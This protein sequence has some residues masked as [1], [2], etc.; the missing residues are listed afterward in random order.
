MWRLIAISCILVC[1]GGAP[2]MAQ[3]CATQSIVWEQDGESHGTAILGRLRDGCPVLQQR[4]GREGSGS[5]IQL[6]GQDCDCDLRI[7]GLEAL[8]EAPSP[9]AAKRM[10]GVCQANRALALVSARDNAR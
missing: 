1:G 10:T 2:V 3:S 5:V 8:F 9:L 6:S 7:D 4:R